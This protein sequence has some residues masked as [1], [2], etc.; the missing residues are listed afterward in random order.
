MNYKISIILSVIL[1]VG[2][3]TQSI[4]AN[5]GE[6]TDYENIMLKVRQAEWSGITDISALDQRV[7][8]VISTI[9]ANGSW[10]DVD[11]AN[12]AQTNWEPLTHLNR[13]K[14]I[15][16]AYTISSSDYYGN[17]EL[18]SK[19]SSALEFWYSADPRST[20]WYNQQ[21]ACPQRI[22]VILILMRAGQQ[23]LSATLETNLLNRMVAIG[24]RPDQSG[25][26]GT[27][28]NKVDIATHWVCRGCLTQDE[29][30]LSFGVQQVYYPVFVTTGEGL[31]SDYSYFQHGPQF[32]TGGYGYSFINGVARVAS[33]TRGTK[34]EMPADK[35]NLLITFTRDAYFRLMRGKYFMYNAIGRGLSRPGALNA[36]GSVNVAKLVQELD[37]DH[38][39]EY[40]SIIDRLTGNQN[41]A[42][43]MSAKH[44]HYWRSD[45]TLYYSPAYNF[46][47][48]M[49]SNRTYRSE[50]G[51]GESLK[52]YFLSE[53]AYNIAVDG[54]EYYDIFPVWDWTK[55]PGITAPQK[56]VIPQPAQWGTY[57]TS[58]FAGGVSNGTAG[59]TAF[60]LNNN[61][62]SINTG[63]RKAWFMFG[64][65]IV[66]LGASIKST[67][68]EDIN[69]TINQCL[70]N[71]DPVVKSA[72]GETVLSSG[73]YNLQTA[74]VNWIYHNKVG[75]V[76]PAPTSLNLT[77][78]TESGN[79]NAINTAYSTD[80]V[81]KDVFK[82][83]INHGNKPQNE[84]YAYI[85]LPGK[86]L[87]EVR[88]YNA[89]N[90]QIYENSD[91]LQVVRN[92][93]RNLWGL[94]FYKAATF[95]YNDFEIK[96]SGSCAMLLKDAD[97]ENVQMWL[98]DPSQLK[99]QINI[100]YA[101]DT[102]SAEKELT[103]ELPVAP[104]AGSTIAFEI[105][106]NTPDYK[107]VPVDVKKRFPT[108]DSFV[109]NGASAS[110]VFGLGTT[111]DRLIIKK[112]N[113]GYNREIMLKF[114]LRGI[115]PDSLVT[116]DLN[117][118]V[119]SANVS[120][121]ATNW[122]LY[123]VE[124]DSWNESTLNWNNKPAYSTLLGTY[125]GSAAGS[126]I[127]YDLKQAVVDEINKGDHFLSLQ[128]IATERGSDAKT[129]AN[130][131]S[132]DAAET[133]M[134]PHLKIETKKKDISTQYNFV[135][136]H[137]WKNM[138]LL[139]KGNSAFLSFFSDSDADAEISICNMAGVRLLSRRLPVYSGKNDFQFANIQPVSGIYFLSVTDVKS[140]D[141]MTYKLFVN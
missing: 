37:T 53:G 3:F 11:Y 123:Y 22:G 26:Q 27:G 131:F 102:F 20:N 60:H 83:W 2:G 114:D 110:T 103:M 78:K 108:D 13:L 24:G 1:F 135:K 54:N 42:Y 105:D 134:H 61:E 66:C 40:E 74:N 96:T 132:K 52:G 72:D 43:N 32:F 45:Y 64:D 119:R 106:E 118:F 44:V 21:I 31:Q 48:R 16:L 35:L 94:V 50:N 10:P 8:V 70:L 56:T 63:A 140:G 30:V 7:S 19:I 121:S 49:A 18:F 68:T 91:S 92:V 57:G 85:F 116:A 23:A 6:T 58:V 125:P 107:P 133:D 9:N 86:S 90:I 104:Y 136:A 47:I 100:R 126:M 59:V 115:Q 137:D 5:A 124:N 38:L 141:R 41:A 62:Y 33:Y 71:G 127:N 97:S 99:K 129:D 15:V 75:Y 46:D 80:N 29:S 87:N 113:S 111:A 138:I 112:D 120:V 39:S 17:T 79:W 65:E 51:N 4:F 139:N 101:S 88:T 122:N 25:S 73:T 55:V 128:M 98:S 82:L 89:E 67:A 14:D 117:M 109:V 69:T 76:F 81:S 28:A 36:S 12:T 34:Y 95:K 130:F 77:N 84:K 93:T